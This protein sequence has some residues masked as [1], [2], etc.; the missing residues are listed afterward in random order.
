MERGVNEDQVLPMA[1]Y[2][3]ALGVCLRFIEFMDVGNHNGWNLER[4][5]SGQ[6][7]LERLQAVF[8]LKPVDTSSNLAVAKRYVY[9]DGSAEVGLITSVTQPFCG[10][11]TRARIS[12]DGKLYTC[13][14]ANT[15]MDLKPL[16]R[17]DDFDAERL[18]SQL[19]KIWGQRRDQYSQLRSQQTSSTKKVEMSYIGG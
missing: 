16:V 4:V 12:A 13:L 5:V 11:C 17:V 2:F 8:E 9:A 6:Q 3:K 14:F 19:A 10:G 15:G 18:Y 1:R 7:I